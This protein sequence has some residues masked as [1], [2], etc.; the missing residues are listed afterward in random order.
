MQRELGHLQ[1]R[2]L[3]LTKELAAAKEDGQKE[4]KRAEAARQNSVQ[5]EKE[6]DKV[7]LFYEDQAQ[8][9]RECHQKAADELKA[10]Y[11]AQINEL[12]ARFK[13]TADEYNS[14]LKH[15][16]FPVLDEFQRLNVA[17]AEAETEVA[18]L[19]GLLQQEKAEGERNKDSER[20]LREQIVNLSS[21]LS[22]SRAKCEEL[23]TQ[24]EELQTSHSA[25]LVMLENAQRAVAALKAEA[26]RQRRLSERSAVERVELE[27]K[28]LT[29][30]EA[31][32]QS[33]TQIQ[34]EC[35]HMQERVVVLLREK[36]SLSAELAET[37][38][39]EEVLR[40]RVTLLE[41][42]L[43]E[44][45]KRAQEEEEMREQEQ[46][47]MADLKE[48]LNNA[49]IELDIYRD[50]M[51]KLEWQRTELLECRER[52]RRL[53]S[54]LLPLT[55]QASSAPDA[56]EEAIARFTAELE[57]L[58]SR[59]GS[60]E[61]QLSNV[62]TLS[63]SESLR[64][65]EDSKKA[66]E[67]QRELTVKDARINA[68]EQHLLRLQTEIELERQSGE[69]RFTEGLPL[70]QH[71]KVLMHAELSKASTSLKLMEQKYEGEM[72]NERRANQRL[73]EQ[74][75]ELRSDCE[76]LRRALQKTQ[77]EVDSLRRTKATARITE[78]ETMEMSALTEKDPVSNRELAVVCSHSISGGRHDTKD[79][80]GKEKNYE[81]L[82][83]RLKHDYNNLRQKLETLRR[84]QKDANSQ[85]FTSN[86]MLL[87]ELSRSLYNVSVD[88]ER[89]PEETQALCV[90][91]EA[92]RTQLQPSN[93]D[94]S[95]IQHDSTNSGVRALQKCHRKMLDFSDV[96]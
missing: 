28:L 31:R 95:A 70:Q 30:R 76:S 59:L 91:V 71:N 35:S 10:G 65:F 15:E 36:E 60:T 66:S 78:K 32:N 48:Q 82:Y 46:Q 27:R 52:L 51:G 23:L 67:L 64:N 94:Q 9:A 90:T 40:G 12:R 93:T 75:E 3:Q 45:R 81:Q 77:D 63:L 54:A 58:R 42:Q 83:R 56:V 2:L 17:V 6:I 13:T 88:P 87:N 16:M 44:R 57:T 86:S 22:Q 14:R 25:Q 4:R 85:E 38:E 1:N 50:R 39:E 74:M 21:D 34:S 18:T 79:H 69:A 53:D 73:R 72:E 55:Q 96:S 41:M 26:D 89:M 11:E 19:R 49:R 68:L 61:H 43:E 20:T 80:H 33:D 84:L 7:R 24:L 5:L 29:L 62:R 92:F 37:R 47:R 8:D